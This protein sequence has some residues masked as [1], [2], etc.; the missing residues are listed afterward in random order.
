MAKLNIMTMT[1]EQREAHNAA[2]LAKLTN[3]S[4]PATDFHRDVLKNWQVKLSGPKPT[5]E[6]LKVNYV[7]DPSRRAGIEVNWVGMTMR[8]NGATVGEYMRATSAGG[9]AHNNAKKINDQGGPAWLMRVPLPNTDRNGRWQHVFTEKG[10]AQLDKRIAQLS[11]ST[12]AVAVSP[13]TVK[14]VA[15]AKAKRAKAK[16]PAKA[17][18]AVIA[19]AVNEAPA[20]DGVQLLG[21]VVT[22]ATEVTAADVQAL[23]DKFN[24]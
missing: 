7:L 21:G 23:A 17:K 10:I 13:A 4:V 18:A 20:A 24:S 16:K 9:A 8:A 22:P 6:M 19:P 12:A 3:L 1:A 15:Q 11:A 14:N 5:L 2:Q